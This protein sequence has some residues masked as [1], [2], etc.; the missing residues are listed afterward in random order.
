VRAARGTGRHLRDDFFE[1]LASA[2]DVRRPYGEKALR[3]EPPEEFELDLVNERAALQRIISSI[4]SGTS[5][6]ASR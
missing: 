2:I 6:G 1:V 3:L 4:G 5:R